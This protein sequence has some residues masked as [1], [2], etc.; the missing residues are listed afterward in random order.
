[1]TINLVLGQSWLNHHQHL[2]IR[3]NEKLSVLLM[4]FWFNLKS[5]A[6]VDSD[7]NH[8]GFYIIMKAYFHRWHFEGNKKGINLYQT[9]LPQ[10]AG[11][12]SSHG[13][14]YTDEYLENNS[15]D[16]YLFLLLTKQNNFSASSPDAIF[17]RQLLAF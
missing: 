6:V 7:V 3:F 8:L 2:N 1:M 4:H 11:A 16:S 10:V 9:L 5:N 13:F 17:G 15:S 14:T 12:P